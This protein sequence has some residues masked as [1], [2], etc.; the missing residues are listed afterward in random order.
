[1]AQSV[2]E[3]EAV[4]PVELGVLVTGDAR[5]RELNREYAGEDEATDV[6]SFSLTEGEEFAAPDGVLRL[7]EVVI[8]Y[9]TAELQAR[10]AGRTTEAE[11]THLLIH[12]ILHLLGYDH[13]DAEEERQMRAREQELL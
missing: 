7:G 2:L 8:S 5:L 4:P 13:V 1:M 10:E 9:P 6:L 3:A 12:G 11:V